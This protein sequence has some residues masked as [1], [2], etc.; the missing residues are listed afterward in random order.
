MAEPMK[1]NRGLLITDPQERDTAQT[2]IES[3]V[4][5]A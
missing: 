3:R 5:A 4:A 2:E 1:V